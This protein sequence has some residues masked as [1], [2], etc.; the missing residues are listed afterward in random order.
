MGT[1]V[2][3]RV[4]HETEPSR[5]PSALAAPP[6]I[7]RTLV[8]SPELSELRAFCAAVDLGSIGRAARLIQVSQ[9]AL[10][11]RLKTLEAVAGTRLLTRS[12]RGVTATPA[13]LRLYAAA[14]R[15]LTDAESVE[16][17]MRGFSSQTA[18]VRVAASPTI[19]DWWLPPALVS[20]ESLHEHHLSVEVLTANS[21]IVRDMVRTG[22]S[23]IGL[24]AIDPAD[25]DADLIET[26][27]WRDEIIVAV[28]I[29]HPW[30]GRDEID[31]GEFA[32]TAIIRRDPSANSSRIVDAALARAGLVPVEPLA[33]IGNNAA[34]RAASLAECAPVLLPVVEVRD[35]P[36]GG[37]VSKR[38]AGMRF[39]RDFSLV[40]A[41]GMHEL[42]CSARTLAQHLIAWSEQVQD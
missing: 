26:V 16:A 2:K 37:L 7:G 31:P 25:G 27:I 4:A 12:P 39:A 24:A 33:Q 11:K 15:L 35:E 28:P 29:A 38:V 14:R 17:L 34:A 13:G 6:V 3:L 8:R 41:A 1:L 40:L 22:R 5:S 21:H 42:A 19:A 30:A 23:D 10:S 20:L 9:P 32:A 18:P 36:A